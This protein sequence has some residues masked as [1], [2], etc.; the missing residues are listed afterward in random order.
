MFLL[1]LIA[2]GDAPATPVGLGTVGSLHPGGRVDAATT[3]EA[4]GIIERRPAETT[5]TSVAIGS[6]DHIWG[7][8]EAGGMEDHRP[9]QADGGGK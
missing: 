1:G 6:T 4:M 3:P 5:T 7:G 9:C 2:L 8:I